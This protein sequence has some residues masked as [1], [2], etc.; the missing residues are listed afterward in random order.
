MIDGIFARVPQDMSDVVQ[1]EQQCAAIVAGAAAS[2][3]ITKL[4]LNACSMGYD[5]DEHL[6]TS[7]NELASRVSVVAVCASIARLPSLQHLSINCGYGL[8]IA[9]EGVLALT[10]HTALTRLEIWGAEGECETRVTVGTAAATALACA[11]QQ[12]QHL[13]LMS[14]GLHLGCTDDEWMACL[15]AVG[16][17]TNLT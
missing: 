7:F 10:A 1:R 3:T 9:Q 17:L 14:C 2:S 4:R 15:G 13:D 5:E 16:R 6:K 8:G 11:L 12:S